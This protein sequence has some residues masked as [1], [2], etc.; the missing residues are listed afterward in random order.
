MLIEI[1]VRDSKN[2]PIA[3]RRF[4]DFEGAFEGLEQVE[5]EYKS[6]VCSHCLGFGT[7]RT[8]AVQIAGEIVDEESSDCPKCGGSGIV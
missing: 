6:V 4:E 5:G 7:S 2:T 8:P 3:T 1:I